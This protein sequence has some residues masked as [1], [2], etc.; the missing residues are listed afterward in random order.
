MSGR[1][2]SRELSLQRS[3]GYVS[4][5]TALR[6]RQD[7]FEEALLAIVIAGLVEYS[8]GDA[9]AQSLH[10]IAADMLIHSRG[11]M[12]NTI[13]AAPNLEPFYIHAQYAFGRCR[14][15]SLAS[16][17]KITTEWLEELQ[18]I[19][20]IDRSVWRKCASTPGGHVACQCAILEMA[21]VQT[22][23]ES[24]AVKDPSS[25]AVG[26]QLTL[27]VEI[28][29]ALMEFAGRCSLAIK[30]F[31]RIEFICRHSMIDG[32]GNTEAC[33]LRAGT[34]ASICSRARRD[35]IDQEIPHELFD[36]DTRIVKRHILALKPFGYLTNK[37]QN[38]VLDRMISWLRHGGGR[39]LSL[40]EGQVDI[41]K[42]EAIQTWYF[43]YGSRT[44]S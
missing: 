12:E 11:G 43:C 14:I 31:R 42:S 5:K 6:R 20:E 16:L 33:E 41:L 32:R 13:K 8:F 29:S 4:L 24:L 36:I 35:V 34:L 17:E 15:P 39:G 18:S 7:K 9:R 19:L 25:F 2:R 26:M 28:T 38:L 44:Q 1:E 22:A 37:G 40:G 21:T 27:L 30:Y 3:N 10:T 23:M